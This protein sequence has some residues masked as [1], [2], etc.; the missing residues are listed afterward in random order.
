[1]TDREDAHGIVSALARSL[2]S[3]LDDE[4]LATLATRLRPFLS[5]QPAVQDM[6]ERLLTAAEAAAIASV[7]VETIRR[8]VRAGEFG[9][10]GK[11]G[12]SPRIA[13]AE[14]RRWLGE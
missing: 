2:T 12:R 14:L 1:M 8:A 9:I 3:G 5:A 13:P 6:Q 11:V 7:H 10:A 4:S